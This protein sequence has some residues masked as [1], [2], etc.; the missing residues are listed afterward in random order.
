MD[1]WQALGIGPQKTKSAPQAQKER[2]PN[3]RKKARCN[4]QKQ[5][6]VGKMQKACNRN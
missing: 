5:H 2:N 6:G 1:L 3:K 4:T